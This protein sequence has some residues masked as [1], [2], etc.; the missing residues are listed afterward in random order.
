VVTFTGA[1]FLGTLVAAKQIGLLRDMVPKLATI[2]LLEDAINRERRAAADV[3]R[4]AEAAGM[5][6]VVVD[7]SS[8]R[9]IDP[10]FARLVEQRVDALVIAGLVFFNRYRDRIVALTAQHRI[11]AIFTNR[12][13]PAAGGLMSYGA[14]ANDAYRQAGVYVG[15]LVKGDKPADLPVT[16][17]TKFELVINLK[18]AKSLSLTIPPGILAIADGGDRIN[19]ILLQC[20]SPLMARL[21]PR[22]MSG[23]WPLSGV[24]QTRYAHIEFSCS[25]LRQM[26]SKIVFTLPRPE[27]DLG[28]ARNAAVQEA[29]DLILVNPV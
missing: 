21:R 2:G 10:A 22:P 8:E 5:K 24:K 1:T 6:A 15:R 18:T 25:W 27:A 3:Q 16:Q 26:T 28:L 23:L 17:A 9:D 19:W 29:P 12:V 11:P 4:S 7:V 14:D 20:M 13:F